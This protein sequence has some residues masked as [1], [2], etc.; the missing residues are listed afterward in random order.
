[1]I[2][3]KKVPYKEAL[4]IIAI[5][6]GAIILRSLHYPE[7]VNF[8]TD[9]ARFAIE[10]YRIWE[11]KE[12]RLIGPSISF[13][14]FDR[15]IFQ[16]SIT[17][18]FQL[19]FLL[20]GRFDPVVSSYLFTLFAS[21]MIIPLNIGAR[22]IGG[23]NVA[24][25][26]AALY[27]FFPFYIDYSRFLW[28]PTFQLSLTPVLILFVGLYAKYKKNYLALLIGLWCGLLLGFHYQYVIVTAIVFVWLRF[29]FALSLKGVSLYILGFCI[30]FA[31]LLLFEIRNQFYNTQ[32]A[33]L[34]LTH[35]RKFFSQGSSGIN[36]YYFLSIL[37]VSVIF[38]LTIKRISI[39]V[40]FTYLICILLVIYSGIRYSAKPQ[41]AFGMAPHWNVTLEQRAS[42]IIRTSGV[43]NYNVVNMGYDTVSMVQKYYLVTN[44]VSGDWENYYD[45]EYLFIISRIGHDYMKDP[46][47]EV[48]TFIPS[49]IIEKW[50]LSDQYELVLRR[51]EG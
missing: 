4:I 18:Y 23:K 32:T 46:A 43:N 20:P 40:R 35:G 49:R 7:S 50:K 37:L 29:Q 8:S 6:L 28:N 1:M 15:E 16:G 17:Y 9:Q 25:L 27:G 24:L 13:K 10:S 42:D 11:N 45:N 44:N 5:V 47:Y 26:I 41:E 2:G 34:F 12:L 51:R 21:F 36:A 48:N 14:A 22:M 31:P 19:L 38:L 3:V 33:L 30:G 39:S